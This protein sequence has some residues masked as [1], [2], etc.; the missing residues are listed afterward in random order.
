[1]VS[2][3]D[4][5]CLSVLKRPPIHKEQLLLPEEKCIIYLYLFQKSNGELFWIPI[6]FFFCL[7]LEGGK[8]VNNLD[9]DC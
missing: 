1:M 6:F 9:E 5:A 3:T 8:K 2:L 7:F 4:F